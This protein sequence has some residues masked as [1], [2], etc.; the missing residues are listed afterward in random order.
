MHIRKRIKFARLRN[1]R[2]ETYPSMRMNLDKITGVGGSRGSVMG[3]ELVRLK[4][5]ES[6]LQK[7]RD[8]KEP[9]ADEKKEQRVSF[10][11]GSLDWESSITREQ[12]R[13]MV[14]CA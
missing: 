1:V 6:L 3:D 10:V 12:V 13:K 8:A 4:S 14:D 2:R 5:N 11:F 7:L 9:S